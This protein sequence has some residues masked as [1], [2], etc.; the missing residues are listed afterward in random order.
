[1][2]DA[3]SERIWPIALMKFEEVLNSYP[4]VKGL[5]FLDADGRFILGS[6]MAEQK[7]LPDTPETRNAVK[8]A[9]NNYDI[10][11]NSNPVPGIIRALRTLY[12]PTD[13]Q[14]KMTIFIMGDEFT[15]T[16]D[17]VVKRLDELNP[18]DQDGKRKVVINAICFPT[19]IQMGFSMG[20]TG[21][22]LS[23]LMRIVTYQ[24]GGAFIALHAL[25][26]E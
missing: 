7:W 21:V 11:T 20:N 16:A 3:N 23:N 22:K 17:A 8:Q 5:Q 18:K 4:E 26:E 9:V 24:H 10:Y 13:E 19:S 2:R 15:G 14:M 1:M 6:H 25:D 12:D